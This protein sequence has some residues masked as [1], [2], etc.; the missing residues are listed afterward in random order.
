MKQY[1]PPA[2]QR[3]LIITVSLTMIYELVKMHRKINPPKI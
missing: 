2:G 1:I 3:S